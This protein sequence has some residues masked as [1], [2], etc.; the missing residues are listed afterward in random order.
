[1]PNVAQKQMHQC[2]DTFINSTHAHHVAPSHLT[3]QSSHIQWNWLEPL[4]LFI[5]GCENLCPLL[6]SS[7]GHSNHINYRA[8]TKDKGNKKVNDKRLRSCSSKEVLPIN[9]KE[10]RMSIKVSHLAKTQRTFPDSIYFPWA[11][12]SRGGQVRQITLDTSFL[13]FL[14]R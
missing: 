1:M 2:R 7:P 10:L 6:Q 3:V 9:M 8:K 4:Y 5:F 11:H 14:Y 13:I 12:T